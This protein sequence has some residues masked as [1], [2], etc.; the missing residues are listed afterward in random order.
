[1][2][3]SVVVAFFYVTAQ[4]AS[5]RAVRVLAGVTSFGMTELGQNEAAGQPIEPLSRGA[6]IFFA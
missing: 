1:V 2:L 3:V 4:T 5:F 6:L